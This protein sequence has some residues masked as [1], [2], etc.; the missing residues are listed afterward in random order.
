MSNTRTH[1][2]VVTSRE[3][4]TELI[5]FKADG[6]KCFRH[7]LLCCESAIEGHPPLSSSRDVSASSPEC[8]KI[9]VVRNNGLGM[10]GFGAQ[11]S[12]Q[13]RDSSGKILYQHGL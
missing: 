7:S 6:V 2:I 8:L 13:N 4:D 3:K 5:P 9:L 12:P 11:K 10:A 1:T